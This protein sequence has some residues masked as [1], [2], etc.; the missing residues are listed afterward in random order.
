[1]LPILWYWLKKM[2]VIKT[3]VGT[4]RISQCNQQKLK[5]KDSYR[6]SEEVEEKLVKYESFFGAF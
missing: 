2:V 3:V 5:G 6:K 1:M 4:S